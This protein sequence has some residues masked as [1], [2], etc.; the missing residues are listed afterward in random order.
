MIVANGICIK[1][2]L[3]FVL[4]ILAYQKNNSCCFIFGCDELIDNN[5][6]FESYLSSFSIP[7]GSMKRNSELKVKYNYTQ[8]V[9][10]KMAS[11]ERKVFFTEINTLVNG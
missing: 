6:M 4:K 10:I 9:Y 2:F 8:I 11:S 1:D 3:C 7:V 5:A